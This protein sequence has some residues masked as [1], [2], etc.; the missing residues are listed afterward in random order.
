MKW[1]TTAGPLVALVVCSALA[2]GCALLLLLFPSGQTVLAIP[3]SLVLAGVAVAVLLFSA[4]L[5]MRA[6]AGRRQE[7]APFPAN[8]PKF[9]GG[10]LAVFLGLTAAIG[11]TGYLYTRHQAA[12]QLEAAQNTL[13]SVADLKVGQISN[14]YHDRLM[15]A[16]T[17]LANPLVQKQIALFLAEPS[18]SDLDEELSAWFNAKAVLNDCGVYLYD[19]DGNIR[20][21][22][23]RQRADAPNVSGDPDFQTALGGSDVVVTDLHCGPA[24][25]KGAQ[26]DIYLSFWIPE[27]IGLGTAGTTGGVLELRVNPYKLLYPLIGSWPTDSPSAETLLVR[28]DGNDVVFLNELRHRKGT[29]LTLRFPVEENQNLPAVQAVQGREGIV[30]GR[31]YR[32]V[33]TLAALHAIPGTPWFMVS[34][35]DLEEILTPMRSQVVTTI[36]VL[37]ALIVASALG[38]GLL[39]RRRDNEWLRQQLAV[40]HDRRALAERYMVLNKHAND[41]ILL[42]DQQGKILEANDRALAAY[43]YSQEEMIALRMRDLRGPESEMESTDG[44][45]MESVHR[46]RD[47]STFP[48]E[49]STHTT[50][51]EGVTYHQSVIRDI[52]ERKQ[53]ARSLMRI[54]QELARKNQELEQIVYVASHDLRSPLVNVQGFSTELKAALDELQAILADVPVPEDKRARLSLLLDE[55]LPESLGYILSGIAKMNALISGL[56]RLSRLGRAALSIGPVDMNELVTEVASTFDFQIKEAGVSLSIGE[57]PSCRGD[58]AQLSQAFSNLLGNALKYLDASRPGVVRITGERERGRSVY[59]IED[60]GMGIAAAHHARVFDLYHR[61]N[62]AANAG[63]GLGLTIVRTVLERQQGKVWLE[64]ELG[65]GARFYVSMPGADRGRDSA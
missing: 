52:T 41:V 37:V 13:L 49:I 47:G 62:P 15:D 61:L 19:R 12:Q 8:P 53:A 24:D 33:P 64:S 39:G 35:I 28:R 6:L 44:T 42:S 27:G 32:G 30:E 45:M 58:A 18:P 59:C 29:A 11:M 3:F 57:L 23:P 55:D 25:A 56:L 2:L 10:L 36:I 22:A 54:N 16:R 7:A 4:Y 65:A 48:V 43:G 5:A 60:N 26:G 34:K 51:I 40:E 50:A 63:E 20:L 31:D 1:K 38:V 21:S 17:L 9:W 46:R 14:W